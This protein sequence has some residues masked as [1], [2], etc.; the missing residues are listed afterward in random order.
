[1]PRSRNSEADL[2]SI[3]PTDQDIQQETAQ[4]RR[5][6]AVK[7]AYQRPELRLKQAQ[8]SRPHTRQTRERIRQVNLGRQRQGESW[9]QG[10][11]QKQLGN[12]YRARPIEIRGVGVFE[13]KRKAIEYCTEQGVIN[14]QGKFDKWLHTRPELIFYVSAERLRQQG[15]KRKK[16]PQF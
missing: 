4:L 7:Q 14:A 16:K 12:Q 13:S 9:I 10:M 6:Q 1:M 2:D 5:R 15:S 3:L 11:R 8:K